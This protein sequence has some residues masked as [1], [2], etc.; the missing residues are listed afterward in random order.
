MSPKY[1][2]SDEQGR[3]I[4]AELGRP[5]TADE[6]ADRRAASSRAHRANQTLINLLL[7]IGAS[8][9]VVVVLVL[10]VVRPAPENSRQQVD[11]LQTAQQAQ[12]SVDS[13]LAAPRLPS[14]WYANR[15][16]L[17]QPG[18]GQ[19]STWEIGLLSPDARY[20]GLTQGFRADATWVADQVERLQPTRTRSYGGLDWRVY[21]HRDRTLGDDAHVAY[22]LVATSGDSTIVLTGS[23]ATNGEF[24]T[25]ATAIGKELQ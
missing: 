11:Y 19:V 8:L 3:P 16:E 17:S 18:D 5:E 13:R 20:V 1:A 15:A 14:G 21:D 24:A 7:A 22:A 9:V 6:I 4:V 2:G 10:V 25:V 23:T 12:A